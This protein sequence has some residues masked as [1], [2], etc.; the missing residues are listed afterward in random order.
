VFKQPESLDED[1]SMW[2]CELAWL[3]KVFAY[4]AKQCYFNEVGLLQSLK[5]S[6]QS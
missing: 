3:K 6:K 2:E 5:V 1:N 4:G